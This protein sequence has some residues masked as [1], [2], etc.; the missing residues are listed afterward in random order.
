[1]LIDGVFVASVVALVK[2]LFPSVQGWVT[3]VIAFGVCAVMALLAPLQVQF[4]TTA[5]WLTPLIEVFKLFL[6]AAGGVSLI[7]YFTKK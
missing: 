4:P 7:K 1:M 3:L 6:T 5:P 2:S